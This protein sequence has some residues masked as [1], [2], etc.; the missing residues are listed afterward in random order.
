MKWA[1]IL[2]MAVQCTWGGIQ[3]LLGFFLF[4]RYIRAPHRFY[5]GSISTGWS[6]DGGISLGLFIFSPDRKEDW[7]RQMEVHEYGHTWQSLMLGPFYLLIIGLP[8]ILWARLPV[9]IRMRREKQ[10]PYSAFYT[11]KWADRLGEIMTALPDTAGRR[12]QENDGYL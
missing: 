7:C 2:Y 10:V 11:E 12:T 1:G 6:L 4:L 8:S 5:H 9:C 3:T